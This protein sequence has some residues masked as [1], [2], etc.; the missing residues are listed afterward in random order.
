MLPRPIKP[1]VTRL[2]GA[3]R[4]SLPQAQEGIIYGAAMPIEALLIKARRD[5][6]CRFGFI[7]DVPAIFLL[8][9]LLKAS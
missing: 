5:I 9:E 8:L 1:I 2:L 6:P 4:P 3:G 7:I